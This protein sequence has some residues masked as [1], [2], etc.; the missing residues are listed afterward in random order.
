LNQSKYSLGKHPCSCA[1]LFPCCKY[2]PRYI[3]I[4]SNSCRI[5]QCC[6]SVVDNIPF[7]HL[8][9]RQIRSTTLIPRKSQKKSELFLNH[10]NMHVTAG[11]RWG[12]RRF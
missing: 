5:P 8:Q 9:L 7:F 11:V 4:Y 3:S 10:G 6:S 12:I 1:C 2:V